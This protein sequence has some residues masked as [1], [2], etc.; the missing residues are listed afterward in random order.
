MRAIVCAR[1]PR[2]RC[3]RARGSRRC[4]RIFAYSLPLCAPA[5]SRIARRIRASNCARASPHCAARNIGALCAHHHLGRASLQHAFT[6]RTRTPSRVAARR[7]SCAPHGTRTAVAPRAPL[8][9][10]AHASL[11]ASCRARRAS[12]AR[13]S[14]RIF[15]HLYRA[16]SRACACA[17]FAGAIKH[18]M[19]SG[20]AGTSRSAPRCTA[21]R[22]SR[23]L[24]SRTR[25]HRL[26]ICHTARTAPLPR[27]GI[28]RAPH[29][30]LP[31]TYHYLCH[32]HLSYRKTLRAP[33]TL[34][35]ALAHR[36][37]LSLK[38]GNLVGVTAKISAAARHRRASS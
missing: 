20:R 36:A 18:G 31:H 13:A 34:A 37:S 30:L 24:F 7:A 35:R 3:H 10:C 19:N 25:T 4:A 14:L 26:F 28:A 22:T 16:A 15:A 11:F 23:C 27:I 33:R 8:L 12:H 6:A 29:A 2:T 9:H 17:S 21:C 32:Y 1:A 5:L 38:S